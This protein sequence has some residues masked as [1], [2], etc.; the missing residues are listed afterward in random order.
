MTPR[1]GRTPLHS[2]RKVSVCALNASYLAS[3]TTADYSLVAAIA[4]ESAPSDDGG[5][6]SETLPSA[7]AS[8]VDEAADEQRELL[9][10]QG[11]RIEELTRQIQVCLFAISF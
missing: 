9:E 6:D 7:D 2:R 11:K 10:S 1:S 8:A 3:P 4:S 5:L